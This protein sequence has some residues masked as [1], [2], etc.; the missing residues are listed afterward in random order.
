M[1]IYIVDT[2]A[3]ICS[4]DADSFALFKKKKITPVN[5]VRTQSLV[6]AC[7]VYDTYKLF[8]KRYNRIFHMVSWKR[9]RYCLCDT[10]GDI[11]VVLEEKIAFSV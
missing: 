2:G 3:F 1:Y 4:P 11:L 7:N 6:I 9:L 5:T 10:K 8:K